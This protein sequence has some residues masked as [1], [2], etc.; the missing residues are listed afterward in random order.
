MV[1]KAMCRSQQAL[2]WFRVVRSNH[3]L[4]FDVGSPSYKKQAELLKGEGVKISKG[5]V[6]PITSDADTSLD[7]LLWR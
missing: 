5:K 3:T 4:A 1:S 7:E 6:I 2:P